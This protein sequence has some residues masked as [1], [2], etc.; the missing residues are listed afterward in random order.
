[1]ALHYKAPNGRIIP[2]AGNGRFRK[3]TLSDFGL[4]CILCPK[5]R[6]LNPYDEYRQEGGFVMKNDPPTHCRHCEHP[7]TQR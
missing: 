5:C 2:R 3:T 1:M 6:G 4:G 7:L